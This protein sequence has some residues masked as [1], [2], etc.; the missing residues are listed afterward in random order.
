[1]NITPRRET[2]P[3][4][5]SGPLPDP[6]AGLVSDG[7][8]PRPRPAGRA[9]PS[10]SPAV[11]LK[12]R[13]V[14][15]E[16]HTILREGLR[17]LL[18]TCPE[19]EVVA[20][21]ANGLE[22]VSKVQKHQPDLVLMDLSMPL[23]NGVEAIREIAQRFP[24]TRT[25]ALTVQRDEGSFL[26]AMRAGA[27]GY[28]L[29]DASCH[30]LLAAIRQVLAGNTYLTPELSRTVLEGYLDN[31][32]KRLPSSAWESLT[33]RERQILKMVAEGRTNRQIADHLC[34]CAKTVDR[35]RANLM[36][37]LDLHSAAALTVFAMKKGLI[38]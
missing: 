1:M 9:L 8:G 34:I 6:G 11:R 35:H 22:A 26:D 25:L 24:Q 21:A 29:K 14:I 28:I 20:E 33:Q 18:A 4:A 3:P 10:G 23:M 37:K 12:R 17:S 2:L 7:S 36:R 38:A 15:A 13:V 19:I 16:D 30:D 32:G 27:S 31:K 5:G